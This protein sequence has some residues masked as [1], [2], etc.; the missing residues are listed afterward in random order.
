MT[1]GN[2]RARELRTLLAKKHD[3]I[4]PRNR[5]QSLPIMMKMTYGELT[6]LLTIVGSA[7]L[8]P[9]VRG[10]GEELREA[11]ARIINPL[12]FKSW[13]SLYDYGVRQRDTEA[14][15]RETADWAHKKDCDEALAKA[16]QIIATLPPINRDAVLEALEKAAQVAEN[17]G[18]LG[19]MSD[20]ERDYCRD[21][22]GEIA[23]QIQALQPDAASRGEEG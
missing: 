19:Y 22:G 20:R 13:Q 11:I 1:Q 23:E 6:A 21:H 3:A 4:H 18:P 12:A 8:T 16:D 2:E 7:A 14:E 5:D 10:H 9:P 17:H 15:A